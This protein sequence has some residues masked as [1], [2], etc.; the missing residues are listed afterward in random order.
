MDF[1]EA[2]FDQDRKLIIRSERYPGLVIRFLKKSETEFACSKLGKCR[3]AT[4]WNG[5]IV[6]WKHPKDA[7]GMRGGDLRIDCTMFRMYN[8]KY[9]KC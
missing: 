8:I 1:G 9:L 3:T 6:S 5:R 4:V 2:T 7:S